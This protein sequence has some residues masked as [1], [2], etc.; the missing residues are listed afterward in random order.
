MK[1]KGFTLIELMVVVAIIGILTAIAYPNFTEYLRKAKRSDGVSALL[2]LQQAQAKFRNGCRFYANT[3]SDTNSIPCTAASTP[4]ITA[5]TD[6]LNI[7]YPNVSDERY[8]ALSITANSSTGYTAIAQAQGAQAADS[9][10]QT[11]ILE[12]TPGNPNGLRKST[13]GLNATG[14]TTTGCW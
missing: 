9:N 12:V 6:T 14:N 5:A 7:D 13:D 1:Q 10:C 11:L 4:P 2:G 3:L 8:Y